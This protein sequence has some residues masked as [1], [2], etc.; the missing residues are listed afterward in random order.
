MFVSVRQRINRFAG[1]LKTLPTQR[2]VDITIVT[3]GLAADLIALGTFLGAIHTS[4]TGSN[5]YVNSREFL[6]W[7]LI[8]IVY[9]IGFLN[10]IVRRRWRRL[11]GDERGDHSVFNVFAKTFIFLGDKETKLEIK[12][13]NFQRDFSFLYIVMFIVTFLFTRAVTATETSTGITSSPWTDLLTTALITIPFTFGMM[14]ITS[15]FDFA[16]SMFAGDQRPN[17]I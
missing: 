15:M 12:C 17:K 5:F 6:A 11:Y 13:R 2:I 9:S 8:A 10:A 4:P 3:I 16:M 7:A 14:V 1:Y